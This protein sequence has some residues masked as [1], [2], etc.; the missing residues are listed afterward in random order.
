MPSTRLFTDR[1]YVA[2]KLP[3]ALKGAHFLRIP[4]DGHKSVTCKRAVTVVPHPGQD[5]NRDSQRAR[6]PRNQ[7]FKMVAIPEIPLFNP[8]STVNYSTL[9]QKDCVA[10]ETILIRKWAVPVRPARRDY[11][12]VN[13]CWGTTRKWTAVGPSA[14]ENA[15][16]Q[17]SS[18]GGVH[19]LESVRAINNFSGDRDRCVKVIP[20][21]A[22][23]SD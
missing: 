3:E 1:D 4:M 2:A 18:C 10:G 13:S 6:R 23:R 21:T 5:R 16:D 17:D 19:D 22:T 8:S 15:P 12:E 14:T 7:G 9:Y 20:L 11:A